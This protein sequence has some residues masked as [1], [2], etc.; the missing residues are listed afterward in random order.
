M[1][2]VEKNK[3]EEFYEKRRNSD[4]PFSVLVSSLNFYI[5]GSILTLFAHKMSSM[6]FYEKLLS[7]SDINI[8]MKTKVK[9]EVQQ[10]SLPNAFYLEHIAG[11]GATFDWMFF[12]N[13]KMI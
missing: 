7:A 1:N 13:S 6:K 11:A 8:A 10:I 2:N 12:D 3:K 9:L 5:T 4:L